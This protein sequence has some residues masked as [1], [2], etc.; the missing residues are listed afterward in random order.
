MSTSVPPHSKLA[1]YLHI[2]SLAQDCGS[3]GGEDRLPYY[4]FITLFVSEFGYFLI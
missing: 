1:R 3:S 2:H 4:A